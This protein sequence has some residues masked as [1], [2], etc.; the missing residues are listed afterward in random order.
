GL[1]RLGDIRNRSDFSPPGTISG[2][3]RQQGAPGAQSSRQKEVEMTKARDAAAL[4]V[5][6]LDTPTDLRPNAVLEISGALNIL[7]THMF[8]LYLKTKNFHSHISAPD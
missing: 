3:P 7:L 1:L 2:S 4:R 6:P 8:A 5:A